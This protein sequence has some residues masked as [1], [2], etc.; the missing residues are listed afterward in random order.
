MRYR[1]F[2]NL[3]P[4]YKDFLQCIPSYIEDT[5]DFFRSLE[6]E[7]LKGPQVVGAFPVTMDVVAWYTNIPHDGEDGGIQAF[8]KAIDLRE[9]KKVLT[10]YLIEC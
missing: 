5:P 6:N 10:S 1:V 3:S 2:N 7:N 9:E 4:N 8:Q